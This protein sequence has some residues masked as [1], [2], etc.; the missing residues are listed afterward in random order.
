MPVQTHFPFLFTILLLAFGSARAHSEDADESLKDR[1]EETVDWLLSSEVIPKLDDYRFVR[2]KQYHLPFERLQSA[3]DLYLELSRDETHIH[4]LTPDLAP[5][6]LRIQ[7]QE[8]VAL[9]PGP[10]SRQ[11]TLDL[12]RAQLLFRKNL[13]AALRSGQGRVDPIEVAAFLAICKRAGKDDA[14]DKVLARMSEHPVPFRGL[15]KAAVER[16]LHER[17]YRY[18]RADLVAVKPGRRAGEARSLVLGRVR[19]YQSSFPTSAFTD[20]VKQLAGLLK[21]AVSDEKRYPPRTAAQLKEMAKRKDITGLV[22]QLQYTAAYRTFN[23]IPFATPFGFGADGSTS[24]EQLVLVGQPAIPALLKALSDTR[25]TYVETGL[26]DDR[27]WRVLSVAEVAAQVLER[28]M[29]DQPLTWEFKRTGLFEPKP[30]LKLIEEKARA[31]WAECQA[32]P[33]EV[34]WG[35]KLDA[36]EVNLHDVAVQ[37]MTLMPEKATELLRTRLPKHDPAFAL[38][39]TLAMHIAKAKPRGYQDL[40]LELIESDRPSLRLSAASAL[41]DIGERPKLDRL[42]ADWETYFIGS[43]PKELRAGDPNYAGGLARFLLKTGPE[44]IDRISRDLQKV[45]AYEAKIVIWRLPVIYNHSR[46]AELPQWRTTPEGQAS[47]RLLIAALDDS[48]RPAKDYSGGERVCDVAAEYLSRF[49]GDKEL[50]VPTRRQDRE[51][52]DSDEKLDAFINQ[53]RPRAKALVK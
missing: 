8:Q 23:K 35:N 15:S 1:V 38:T 4:C 21:K 46:N 7:Q 34:F 39:P 13:V 30:H 24:A 11:T 36:N 3:S 28:L 16:G 49:V 31:W 12:Q 29:P 18:L 45:T 9:A 43:V 17:H 41:W 33:P 32:T 44:S 52:A 5:K 10:R 2:L 53:I 47:G 25:L 40:L 51:T 48:R 50:V 42:W 27:Y 22:N 20:E 26:M 37:V 6:R 19:R 14:Y